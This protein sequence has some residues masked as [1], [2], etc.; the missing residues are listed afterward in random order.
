MTSQGVRNRDAAD[1]S[2]RNGDLIMNKFMIVPC[3]FLMLGVR[4]PMA[5]DGQF[6]E[7]HEG[8]ASGAAGF[9]IG[10]LVGA[11]VGGPVGALVGAAGGAYFAEQDAAKDTAIGELQVKL[12][13]RESQLA[14]LKSDFELTQ[15][16]MIGETQVL[17]RTTDIPLNLTV[18][19]RSNGADIEAS[20]QPHL[21]QL[22]T[23]LKT[24]PDLI[25]QLEGYS[26][27]RGSSEHNMALSQRRIDA[28]RRILEESGIA[29]ER[30]REH[31]YGESRAQAGSGDV[32]A[33][34][35]D[36]A[37]IISIDDSRATRA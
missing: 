22:A 17:Q 15:V 10:A 14:V 8:T 23:Y 24:Y 26:D 19:F 34:I 1:D 13:E 7:S 21:V 18:Y 2:N 12:D 32:D 28:I 29:P 35:F 36:R 37:V 16:A 30:M 27:R 25:V 33:M 4:V 5:A 11:L 31:A 9:G 3:L 6:P 20:L